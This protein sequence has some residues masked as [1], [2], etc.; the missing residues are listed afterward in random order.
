M[1]VQTTSLA[2]LSALLVGVQHGLLGGAPKLAARLEI[3]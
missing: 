3:H 1:Q 2:M